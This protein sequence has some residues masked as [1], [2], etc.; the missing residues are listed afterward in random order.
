[1]INRF[2]LMRKELKLTLDD[3]AKALGI[4]HGAVANWEKRG[5]LPTDR[6]YQIANVF[7]VNINWLL[8][9]QGEM[10]ESKQDKFA[11]ITDEEL[12]REYAR[13]LFNRLPPEL[14]KETMLFIEGLTQKAASVNSS[15]CQARHDSSRGGISEADR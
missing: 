11:N 2:K 3:V 8:H 7:G 14:Q 9:G 10:L 12:T 6:A 4:S 15:S 5:E 13:R 1:M